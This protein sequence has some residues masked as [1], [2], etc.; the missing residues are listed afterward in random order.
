[1]LPQ[2]CSASAEL[3]KKAVH[4]KMHWSKCSSVLSGSALR[5]VVEVCK[6]HSSAQAESRQ[7]RRWNSRMRNAFS[8]L[9]FSPV[10]RIANDS[11]ARSDELGGPS[12]ASSGRPVAMAK[13]TLCI[14]LLCT[15]LVTNDGTREGTVLWA[16]SSASRNVKAPI[17]TTLQ[18][19]RMS[20]SD[21]RRLSTSRSA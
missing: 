2:S 17:S 12:C 19:P 1:M 8:G 14:M 9:S 7:A 6:V 16:T 11:R 18:R 3:P 15:G 20:S 21:S 5:V 4:E 10:V 13:L